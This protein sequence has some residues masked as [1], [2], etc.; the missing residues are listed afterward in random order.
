MQV[1]CMKLS[2]LGFMLCATMALE[3]DGWFKCSENTFASRK[4]RSKSAREG[5]RRY[6]LDERLQEMSL[7]ISS[8]GRYHFQAP[9]PTWQE[10]LT[11][12]TGFR[13]SQASKSTKG[14]SVPQSAE[15]GKFT[16]PLCHSGVCQSNKSIH[17][18][19]K[20][21]VALDQSSNKTLWI[22]QGGPG[23]SSAS[24]MFSYFIL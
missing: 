12:K 4:L 24:S 8:K 17:V 9:T 1:L 22:L 21:I 2:V 7:G 19:V 14:A 16:L 23:A 13:P 11:K 20:R 6:N 15:C 18:F 3:L 10:V 5:H